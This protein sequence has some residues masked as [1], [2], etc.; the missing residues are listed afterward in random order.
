M[1]NYHK[2]LKYLNLQIDEAKKQSNSKELE[3]GYGNL[4]LTLVD[5]CDIELEKIEN[6]KDEEK[7]FKKIDSAISALIKSLEICDDLIKRKEELEYCQ[8]RKADAFL[9]L[10]TAYL[11]KARKDTDF[12]DKAY[13]TFQKSHEY[14]KS[15]GYE[16]IEGK[17]HFNKGLILYER[18]KYELA[19]QNFRHDEK[20]CL[21][22]KEFTGLVLVYR[23]LGQS[24]QAL[25][26]FSEAKKCFVQ[27]HNV[28]TQNFP[29]D[30]LLKKAIEE[31]I[32]D[33]TEISKYIETLE[34][35]LQV[36]YRKNDWSLSKINEILNKI[37]DFDYQK[38]KMLFSQA[39]EKKHIIEA[40]R[41][42]EDY[43][44]ENV[45]TFLHHGA[46]IEKNLGNFKK[47]KEYFELI[48]K[49]SRSKNI[50]SWE[51]ISYLL[52]YGNLLDEIK[53]NPQEIEK[54]YWKV[55]EIS[56]EINDKA[57]I[58]VALI[59]LHAFYTDQK[60]NINQS[61]V[62][63]MLMSLDTKMQEEIASENS[64]V[65]SLI[66]EEID[67]S[68][69]SMS[70]E[71]ENEE[72]AFLN[73]E[74]ELFTYEEE[75]DN[76]PQKHHVISKINENPKTGSNN[77]K[78]FN[79][80]SDV[81]NFYNKYCAEHMIWELE[82]IKA[83]FIQKQLLIPKQYF[84]DTL[85]KP[86]F[87]S[88]KIFD[89]LMSL[90]ISY[91][92]LT[93]KSLKLLSNIL[94][95]NTK[96]LHSLEKIDISNN[97]FSNHEEN[98]TKFL[99][100]ICKF[101]EKIQILNVSGMAFP[102]DLLFSEIFQIETLQ[103]LKCRG[104][105]LSDPKEFK[106]LRIFANNL[107]EID[108]SENIFTVKTLIFLLDKLKFLESM[109]FSFNK[110]KENESF[111][112]EKDEK[113]S[114]VYDGRLKKLKLKG[115]SFKIHEIYNILPILE[116]LDISK[117][118][119]SWLNEV[120]QIFSDY[121]FKEK[122]IGNNCSGNLKILKISE[123]NRRNNPNVEFFI[124]NLA[125]MIIHQVDLIYIDFSMNRWN[126]AQIIEIMKHLSCPI[127]KIALFGNEINKE[128]KD[129]IKEFINQFL[130][131]NIEIFL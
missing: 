7:F 120:L 127:K 38:A 23:N 95:K 103:K 21:S 66:S 65:F 11:V 123:I 53:G 63:N 8:K 13:K 90:D 91:N 130:G 4:G 105:S 113:I 51:Y 18:K 30:Y 36:F 111:L 108:L 79:F 98:L 60:D 9:N 101:G 67:E 88:L 6:F 42:I 26:Q 37:Y 126:Y 24:Y 106:N 58:E 70:I 122:Y 69:V 124:I 40:I 1:K 45:I 93:N 5:F 110:G 50:K 85:L 89:F 125:K 78:N 73:Q 107:N 114:D 54:I 118:D 99:S 22:Q 84:G 2:A 59:N 32:K 102:K 31:K 82:I 121:F 87:K 131:T 29:Q 55:Y 80:L 112:E 27:A 16:L 43:S 83:S 100:L 115:V 49:I 52:D 92:R 15:L 75:Y 41:K 46:T 74:E 97:E 3:K 25:K 33:L 116:F 96:L 10:G 104:C 47:A 39:I 81:L 64:D 62:K 56:K 12:Y 35:E 129:N 61:K 72:K 86:C 71:E 14:A 17:S 109:N 57:N 68:E 77:N 128:E 76:K 20:I 117:N 34:H 94:K 119:E 44:Y 48:E 19:I 28:A